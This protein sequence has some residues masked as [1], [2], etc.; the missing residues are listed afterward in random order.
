MNKSAVKMPQITQT[1]QEL[2]PKR[3]SSA[4][5]EMGVRV[6]GERIFLR[7]RSL[8]SGARHTGA[9]AALRANGEEDDEHGLCEGGCKSPQ[10][11]SKDG[12]G[13]GLGWQKRA[14]ALGI[15]LYL[16][17]TA[18][19]F[20]S[21]FHFAVFGGAAEAVAPYLRFALFFISYIFIG[22]DI[23]FKAFSNL[24]NPKNLFDENFLMSAASIGAFAIG[25]YPEAVAVMLLYKI[26]EHLQNRAVANSRRS[27]SA[28]LDIKPEFAHLKRDGA[29]ITVA[30]H[31]V[32]LGDI[33]VVKPGERTPLDGEII[34][35]RSFLDLSAL[36]GESVPKEV[37]IGDSILS[38]SINKSG[39]LT[40]KVTSEFSD[41]TVSKIIKFAREASANKAQTEYFIR[42][43]AK[44][45]TPIVVSL[46]LLL[47][48]LP[49]LIVEGAAFG[50]WFYRA[51]VFLVIACPCALVISVPLSF[52]AGIG[53]ASKRGILVKGGNYLEAL[54]RVQAVVFDK[55]GTLTKGKFAVVEIAPSRGFDKEELLFYAAHAESASPHPIAASIA[56]AYKGG[57]D[58]SCIAEHEEIFGLGAKAVVRSKIVLIGGGKLME[59]HGIAYEKANVSSGAVYAAI[60][61]VFAG[62]IVV[63]DE[64]KP[65]S[66]TIVGELRRLGVKRVAMLTGDQKGIGERIAAQIGIKEVFAQLLP[67]QKVERIEHMIE[68][69]SRGAK[70]AFVGDGV[71]DAP[72][73]ARA[74]I[75]IAMGALGSD[76]ASQAADVVLMNDNPQSVAA[77]IKIGKKTTLVASENIALALGVKAAVL[78]LGAL[79]LTGM[80]AAIF[81]D[82]GVSLIAVLN[83]ARAFRI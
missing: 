45:Y 78:A 69:L 1:R 37:A 9:S 7:L 3:T 21:D 10:D 80:W 64:I 73:L 12:G 51:L 67:L 15:A 68:E 50:E 44:V 77:A 70:L 75:G 71:N 24:K 19:D 18:L 35:G 81:A 55:T 17:G 65:E 23:V 34:S 76:I 46:A 60:D 30:P 57:I 6:L 53:G 63:S 79:G 16:V 32:R 14:I 61:G 43:F 39:M 47:A 83:A 36:S 25:E 22:R 20:A 41:S 2:A 62:H 66:L 26:G 4:A 29:L 49:P 58:P 31:E 42:K 72:S 28:L 82:V 8:F 40:V 38:G 13:G 33:I 74:D 52:F 5:G 11:G 27:I 59:E 56:A 54:S 48:V